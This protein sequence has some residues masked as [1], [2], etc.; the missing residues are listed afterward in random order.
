MWIKPK[1]VINQTKAQ[2]PYFSVVLFIILFK[3]ILTFESVVESL[4]CDNSN[5]S[6]D[7]TLCRGAVYYTVEGGSS[8]RH[9]LLNGS[10]T[11]SSMFM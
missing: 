10:L 2:K 6:L 7:T 3:V 9:D 1:D 8:F 4:K 11:I 5:K